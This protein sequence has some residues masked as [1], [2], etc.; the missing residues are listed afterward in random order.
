[1][2]Q[3]CREGGLPSWFVQK[4][5]GNPVENT[6]YTTATPSLLIYLGWQHEGNK[7]KSPVDEMSP[8]WALQ[9]RP[10]ISFLSSPYACHFSFLFPLLHVVWGYKRWFISLLSLFFCSPC[11]MSINFL[12]STLSNQ[13]NW[14]FL[15][16]TST[17]M[18]NSIHFMYVSLWNT[19]GGAEAWWSGVNTTS[20]TLSP[21]GSVDISF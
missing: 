16:I 2:G 15:I 14:F 13:P 6:T 4:S 7:I 12:F 1:M 10:I 20:P 17:M 3:G 21:T 18:W 8:V 9:A 19:G 11:L 5:P